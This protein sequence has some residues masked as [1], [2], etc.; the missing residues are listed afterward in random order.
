MKVLAGLHSFLEALGKN[1]C[2][3]QSSD[4][5]DSISCGCR[6]E[7]PLFLLL[8]SGM[9]GSHLLKLVVLGLWLAAFFLHPQSQQ[10]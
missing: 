7:I 10:W 2:P 6:T 5:Q 8:I 3:V 9:E 4:W 1:L